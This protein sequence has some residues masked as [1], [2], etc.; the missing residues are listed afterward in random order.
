MA[1]RLTVQQRTQIAARYEVW[2]SVVL[3]QRWWR[4][5]NGG[6]ATIRP[7]TIKN[8]HRKLMT[9]GS[10][11]DERRIG[12]PS[13]SRSDD[14]VATV[15]EMFQRSSSKT[16]RQAARESGLTRYTVCQILHKELHFRAWKPH[17]VQQLTPEDCDRRMEY[18]ELTSSGVMRPYSM[19]EDLSID[20]IV[21]I[22]RYRILVLRS[23]RR[24]LVLK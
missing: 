10:V 13:T 16:T 8:C 4:N 5:I 22:V 7:E 23:R 12:H 2:N 6:N 20:T 24:S 15:Q 14:N 1:D 21:I 18:G 11:K 17:Y 19:L 3:V 9:T